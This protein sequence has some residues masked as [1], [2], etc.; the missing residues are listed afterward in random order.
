[1]PAALQCYHLQL[2]VLYVLN[3]HICSHFFDLVKLRHLHKPNGG[4]GYG[5]WR[6]APRLGTL[7]RHESYKIPRVYL[8]LVMSN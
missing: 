8:L 5:V 6:S 2:F 4:D 1:M 3:A 7:T